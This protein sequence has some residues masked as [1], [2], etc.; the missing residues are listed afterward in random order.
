MNNKKPDSTKKSHP[1]DT[2]RKKKKEQIKLQSDILRNISD[3]VYTTDLQFRLTSWNN[4]AEIKYGWE[5]DEVLGKS[6]FE[7]V[8]SKFD[9]LFSTQSQWSGGMHL[10]NRMVS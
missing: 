8:G 7:F 6:V 2:V 10:E 4:A 3:V 9:L 1:G 5:E